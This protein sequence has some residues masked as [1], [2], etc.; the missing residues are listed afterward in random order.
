VRSSAAPEFLIDL[1][2]FCEGSYSR[3]AGR[4]RNV[5]EANV[6]EYPA[7]PR[8][9][10]FRELK[11]KVGGQVRVIS[12]LL[13]WVSRYRKNTLDGIRLSVL[14]FGQRAYHPNKFGLAPGRLAVSSN[15]AP[16]SEPCSSSRTGEP[17]VERAVSFLLQSLPSQTPGLPRVPCPVE[18][19][20]SSATP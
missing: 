8:I 18:G 11:E 1:V 12:L 4:Y 13:F 14:P 5:C 3:L 7:Q 15:P 9:K 6:S 19:G 2:I 17:V 20:L 16:S 10:K